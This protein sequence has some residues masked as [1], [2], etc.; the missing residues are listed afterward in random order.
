MKCIIVKKQRKTANF[1]IAVMVLKSLRLKGPS[2]GCRWS[3]LKI[4]SLK[5]NLANVRQTSTNIALCSCLH[6]FG[7][8]IVFVCFQW[9]KFCVN[10]EATVDFC[11]ELENNIV[12]E[13][14]LKL[15]RVYN[16]DETGL[17][18]RAIANLHVKYRECEDKVTLKRLKELLICYWI[19]SKNKKPANQLI[20]SS[21]VSALLIANISVIR[22]M[23]LFI[24]SLR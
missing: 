9:G 12:T 11:Y 13:N 4:V 19:I 6:W 2:F 18:W 20:M 23:S 21:K 1:C 17:Y 24:I 22:A 15:S 5:K 10:E 7:K 16:A 3:A 8:D 14:D